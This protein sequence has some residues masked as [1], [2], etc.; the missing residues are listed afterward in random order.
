[1]SGP[2]RELAELEVMGVVWLEM[3]GI[4]KLEGRGTALAWLMKWFSSAVYSSEVIC[5][6]LIGLGAVECSR[7]DLALLLAVGEVGF[8]AGDRGL[9]CW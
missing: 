3:V 4:A 5:V 1:M 7:F 9:V 2:G 6:V 8:G